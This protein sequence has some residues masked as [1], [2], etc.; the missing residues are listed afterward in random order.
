MV[1]RI[2]LVSPRQKG[3]QKPLAKHGIMGS[4]L[5]EWSDY[6]LLKSKLRLNIGNEV[7]DIDV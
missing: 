2:V 4:A 3:V 1:I 6:I 7:S 5:E